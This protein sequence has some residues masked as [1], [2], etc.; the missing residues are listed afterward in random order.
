M[1]NTAICKKNI[2]KIQRSLCLCLLMAQTL[3]S[4]ILAQTKITGIVTDER[5][6]TIIGANVSLVGA[7][8]GTVTDVN[9][10]FSLK[11][12]L[13]GQLKVSFVGYETKVVNIDGKTSLKISLNQSSKTFNEVVVVGY[14][15]QKKESVVGS[16]VQTSNKELRRAGGVTD[17]KQSLTG[18]LPGVTTI[19]STGEP[20]GYGTGQSSTAIYIRGQNTWNGGQPLI[21]VDGV[22]RRMENIDVNEVESISV[23][24]DASATAVFGV[25]GANGVILITTKR[26]DDGKAQISFSYNTTGLMLSKLPQRL[27]SY[28]TLLYKNE[29]I[30][31]EVSLNEASWADYTPND[32]ID[33]YK[34]PQSAEYAE[35]YPNVDWQS[36]IF[37]DLGI[38]HHASMDIKGGTNFVKYFGSFS[39]VH[40]GDMFND[41][42]SNNKGYD[43]SYAF[44][45]FNFRSNLDF[46]ITPTT[47][48]KMNLSGFY[49]QKNTNYDYA[50]SAMGY[51][52]YVWNAVYGMPS[53][54]YLPQYSDGRWGS[55]WFYSYR[56][57]A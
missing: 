53:D 35:I 52:K 25:K 19:V 1:K 39:Y 14:G 21:L 5:N 12:P 22:E 43:P 17:L 30:E 56:D 48:F 4:P 32:I 34:T 46:K 38:S 50:E 2:V 27:D 55:F 7:S 3:M 8:A 49:S 13:N 31:R 29:A 24:K 37:K 51:N 26:G 15:V 9:G 23:L 45:R 16:I 11:A 33:R 18:N 42:Y 41:N 6:E 28:N 20:G 54:A 40:E 36:A 57:N 47:N 10:S 44:N